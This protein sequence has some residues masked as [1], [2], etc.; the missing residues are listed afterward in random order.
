[1]G[2]LLLP[3]H[4]HSFDCS[5][6]HLKRNPWTIPCIIAI[7]W[8]WLDITSQLLWQS[9]CGCRL[10]VS[11][12]GTGLYL[13]RYLFPPRNGITFSSW[14]LNIYGSG[15]GG[16]LK[17]G[18]QYAESESKFHWENGF[19]FLRMAGLEN[20]ALLIC[21]LGRWHGQNNTTPEALQYVSNKQCLAEVTENIT[22]HW[23][24][25]RF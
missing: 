24:H 7:W 14:P 10:P 16:P 25:A 11:M 1:M 17:N 13:F 9:I 22:V 15:Q 6:F 8:V 20:D 18:F 2:S 5:D 3:C 21:C 23:S 12:R 19:S 4:M